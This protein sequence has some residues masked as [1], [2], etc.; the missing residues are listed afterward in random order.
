MKAE[1]HNGETNHESISATFHRQRR[2]LDPVIN[3]Q[4][5]V[6]PGRT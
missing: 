4:M 1:I 5:V 6:M 3:T 2:A